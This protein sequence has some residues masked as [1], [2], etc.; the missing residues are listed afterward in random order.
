MF[1]TQRRWAPAHTHTGLGHTPA[2]RGTLEENHCGSVGWAA[3]FHSKGAAVIYKV[4]IRSSAAFALCFIKYTFVN[5]II[6][7]K[8]KTSQDSGG[9]DQLFK[10]APF[11]STASPS[12]QHFQLMEGQSPATFLRQAGGSGIT[13]RKLQSRRTLQIQIQRKVLASE[14]R[15]GEELVWGS[16]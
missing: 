10:N 7:G 13:Q 1:D 15:N 11:P 6:S 14:N 12:F 2:A 5:I 4:I 16:F 3:A 8:G 9:S